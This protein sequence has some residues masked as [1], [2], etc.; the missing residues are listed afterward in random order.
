MKPDLNK[1]V[2]RAPF[3][4]ILT[5]AT[6]NPGTLVRPGQRLGEFIDPSVYEI[7]IA[8]QKSMIP[9]IQENDKVN[10]KSLGWDIYG[11]RNDK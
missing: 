7:Q 8:L 9:F 2:V 1:F 11:I 6:I 5:E 10:L 3:T 4:G